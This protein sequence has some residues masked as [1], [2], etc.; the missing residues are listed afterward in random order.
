MNFLRHPPLNIEIS[1]PGHASLNINTNNIHNS[2]KKR[3]RGAFVVLHGDISFF[4]KNK[5]DI[6]F[7]LFACNNK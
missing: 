2:Q 1:A 4:S 7:I 3:L 6:D 5:H